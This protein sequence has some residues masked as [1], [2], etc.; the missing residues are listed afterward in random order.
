MRMA[1][2]ALGAAFHTDLGPRFIAEFAQKTRPTQYNMPLPP[3]LGEPVALTIATAF[4]LGIIA[5][6]HSGIHLAL[7][8]LSSILFLR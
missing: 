4:A 1:F 8:F 5:D 6:A 7:L 3:R 2:H